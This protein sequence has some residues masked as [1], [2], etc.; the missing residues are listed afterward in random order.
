MR[1]VLKGLAVVSPRA[2]EVAAAGFAAEIVSTAD[3]PAAAAAETAGAVAE[4]AR[5]K[6]SSQLVGLRLGLV[7]P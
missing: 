3:V 1:P 5:S 7:E 4:I 6:L 2:A